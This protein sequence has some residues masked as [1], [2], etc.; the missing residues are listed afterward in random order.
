VWL[1]SVGPPAGKCFRNLLA[2]TVSL[3]ERRLLGSFHC[4][5]TGC[6]MKVRHR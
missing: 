6:H 3:G 5:L 4:Y 2:A 1:P